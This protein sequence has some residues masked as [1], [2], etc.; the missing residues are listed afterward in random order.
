MGSH[1]WR[2]VVGESKELWDEDLEG[3]CS[4]DLDIQLSWV[5]FAGFIQHVERGLTKK[6]NYRDVSIQSKLSRTCLKLKYFAS[7][8]KVLLIHMVA[9]EGDPAG[10]AVK[11]K[12][13]ECRISPLAVLD[14]VT[15]AY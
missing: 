10:G 1:F 6:G 7:M 3:P 8:M 14:W 15:Q 9:D 13:R 12:G 2:W 4:I 11:L 5:I